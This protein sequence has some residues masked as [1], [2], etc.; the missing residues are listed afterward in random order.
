MPSPY[1]TEL[2]VKLFGVMPTP[3]KPPEKR[4]SPNTAILVPNRPAARGEKVIFHVTPRSK[5]DGWAIHK[6]GGT[7]PSAVCDT[8]DE[9]VSRA[10]EIAQNSGW[11]QVVVH[12]KDGKVAQ[13]F[14]YGEPP[15]QPDE[16]D[17]GLEMTEIPE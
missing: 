15:E 14:H 12:N 11:S 17:R 9:A 5:D 7:R 6:E 4:E 8:K 16:T 13:E 2:F 3:P 10:R 1:S